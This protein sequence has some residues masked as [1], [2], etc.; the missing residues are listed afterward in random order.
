M[1]GGVIIV[2]LNSH[3]HTET[4]LLSNLIIIPKSSNKQAQKD[5]K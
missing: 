4:S 5:I 3:H 1:M 2:G